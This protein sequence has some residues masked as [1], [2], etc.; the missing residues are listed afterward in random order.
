[1]TSEVEKLDKA[2]KDLG[3]GAASTGAN[4]PIPAKAADLSR[5]FRAFDQTQIET[6]LGDAKTFVGSLEHA[7]AAMPDI[8]K[9]R[10]IQQG[11]HGHTSDEE[12]NS[13][14]KALEVGG[15]TADEKKRRDRRRKEDARAAG[16]GPCAGRG[17]AGP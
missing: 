4:P 8:L 9:P 14:I 11:Q 10:T 2:A 1:M 16:K 5:T 6:M 7:M 17:R 3:K 12:F 15:V 13:L